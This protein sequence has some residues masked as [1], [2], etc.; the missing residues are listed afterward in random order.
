M[1]NAGTEKDAFGNCR[2][3][4][5]EA[6]SHLVMRTESI[7]ASGYSARRGAMSSMRSK[8]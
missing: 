8:T 3:A 1:G 7:F 2:M 5:G 6:Q 4:D